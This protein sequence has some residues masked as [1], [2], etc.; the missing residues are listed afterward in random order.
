[1]EAEK[2]ESVSECTQEILREGTQVPTTLSRARGRKVS[3]IQ[4]PLRVMAGAEQQGL[5]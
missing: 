5:R 3:E 4:S 1:M 2:L